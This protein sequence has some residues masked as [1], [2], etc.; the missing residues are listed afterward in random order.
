MELKATRVFQKNWEA[1]SR[2]VVNEG[3]TRSSKT[4]SIAQVFAL[5]LLQERGAV[6]TI[7][8]KTL[9]ALRQSAMKDYLHILKEVGI[10]KVEDHNKTELIYRF[11][12]R[13]NQVEFIAV[14]DPQKIRGRKR[15]YL[16]MNEANEFTLE[17]FRQLM[18]RTQKQAFLDYNPSDEFHWI[19]DYVIPRD[20]ATLI[21]STYKDNPFLDKF[22]VR[23]IEQ[24]REL[25]QNYWRI[26]GLGERGISETTIYTH[27][28]FVDALPEGE[29]IYGLDFGFNNPTS[30]VRVS[31]RDQ[32]LYVQEVIH[33]T[34][35]TNTELIDAIKALEPKGTEIYA[36]SE[37]PNRIE[38]LKRAGFN[39]I[40]AKKE[41]G[42]V[43]AGIDA[44][45]RRRL[46]ITKDSLNIL[47]EVKSYRWK[48][49]DGKTLDEPVKANDH[50]MDAM[51]Y[52]VYTHTNQGT[53]GIY[54]G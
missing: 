5:K 37:D 9:P 24:Y 13:D 38:E 11:P 45:K 35:M 43:Q 8:R 28:S 54:L 34:R 39:A 31:I 50:S 41:K 30:L 10:Y 46:Y 21:K 22:T 48:E 7:C 4:Y 27:W 23:E 25:D 1:G 44:I 14:D 42:S 15:D 26:Y 6:F 40:P 49:K 33:Q 36:D 16:W 17:D 3:G 20:D 32:N 19:Y 12:E 18:L 47:K 52:A 53:P 51:R 2:V 29:V